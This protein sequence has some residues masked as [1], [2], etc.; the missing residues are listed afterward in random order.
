MQLFICSNLKITGKEVTVDNAT[1]IV[2]QLR[3]VLR[4]RPWYK[5]FLQDYVWEKRYN[6]ELL[7]F[8]K[9]GFSAVIHWEEQHQAINNQFWML[10]AIPNKQEKLELIVQKLTEIWISNIYLWSAERS[11]VND[12]NENK[13]VRLN[14]IIREAV[15][16]SWWRGLPKLEIVKDLK[17]LH[18]QRKFVIFDIENSDYDKLDRSELPVLW[19][20]WPE[21]WLTQNDYNK[22]PNWYVIKS[23]WDSVLRMETAAI[24]WWWLIKNNK[25]G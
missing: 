22:F 4:A 8:S 3:K 18:N 7:S 1:E 10:I 16:Q 17:M 15:E 19:V 5:F 14:R 11:Q 6:V 20:I 13:L 25:I 24:V 23:L 21:W 2:N 12:I 9:D